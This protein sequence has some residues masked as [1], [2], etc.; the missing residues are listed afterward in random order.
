MYNQ[1]GQNEQ[2]ISVSRTASNM[3]EANMY[4]AGV[5]GT[6]LGCAG[7]PIMLYAQGRLC[8]ALLRETGA[9]VGDGVGVA[10]ASEKIKGEKLLDLRI[11]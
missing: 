2:R 4:K 6:S 9:E 8:T 11:G 3:L 1:K 5:N 10:G 7:S